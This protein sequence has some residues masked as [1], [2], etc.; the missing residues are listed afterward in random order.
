MPP[1]QPTEPTASSAQIR[2]R[3]PANR[4]QATIDGMAQSLRPEFL[5]SG[6]PEATLDE[7]IEAAVDSCRTM[8]WSTELLGC[9]DGIADTNEISGCQ[10]FMTTE[11]SD[12]VSRRMMDIVSRMSQ[13]PV[14]PPP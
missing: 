11:Q 4:C 9:F 10:K 14:S 1:P 2:L 3:Q 12:D 13:Q 7:L 6:I 8:D 5:R